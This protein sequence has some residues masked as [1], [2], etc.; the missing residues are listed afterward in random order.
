[1]NLFLR[2]A[3]LINQE[4]KQMSKTRTAIRSRKPPRWLP[5]LF[6]PIAKTVLRSPLHGLLSHQLLLITFTGRKSGKVFTT[7]ALYEQEG[8]IV[9]LR[10]GYPWWRNLRGEA[11][12]RVRLRGKAYP[13]T[14]EVLGEEE[15]LTVVEVHLKG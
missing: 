15:G 8:E 13:A 12:V 9:R 2:R 10:I 7:P 4:N 11:S 5:P 1:L 3:F 6:N 14:T